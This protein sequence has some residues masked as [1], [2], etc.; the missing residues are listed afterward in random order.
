[1]DQI[2]DDRW[3]TDGNCRYCRRQ[4]YCGRPCKAQR[5]RKQA[6]LDLMAES[7]KKKG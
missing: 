3:K 2:K 7:R 1:M 5:M 4:D 6:I